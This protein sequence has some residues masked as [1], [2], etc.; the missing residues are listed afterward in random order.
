MDASAGQMRR[1]RGVKMSGAQVVVAREKGRQ[2][3]I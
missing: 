2:E 3:K 1:T